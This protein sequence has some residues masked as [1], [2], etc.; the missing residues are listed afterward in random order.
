MVTSE[1]SGTTALPMAVVAIRDDRVD[2]GA[3]VGAVAAAGDADIRIDTPAAVRSVGTPGWSRE[4]QSAAHNLLKT[5]TGENACSDRVSPT[6]T[7]PAPGRG[8]A[9]SCD[10]IV[11]THTCREHEPPY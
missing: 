4:R 7:R 9:G 8:M 2:P 1:A 6:R 5:R 10:R 11:R 3:V